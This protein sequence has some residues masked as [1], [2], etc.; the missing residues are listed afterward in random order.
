MIEIEIAIRN[1]LRV[2][3]SGDVFDPEPEVGLVTQYVD[4]ME[5]K[6]LS[7]HPVPFDLSDEDDQLV[8]NAIVDAY[9]ESPCDY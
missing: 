3:A 9:N 4:N 7:G 5:V 2:R 8:V 6:F 1:G